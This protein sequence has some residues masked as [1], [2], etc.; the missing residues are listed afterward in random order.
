MSE[1]HKEAA[2]RVAAGQIKEW[3]LLKD[4]EINT[5]QKRFFREYYWD[6][7]QIWNIHVELK[8]FNKIKSS[9]SDN[10]TAVT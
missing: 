1:E 2:G 4:K 5:K 3:T 9:E 8:Y 7:W 10:Y 6:I